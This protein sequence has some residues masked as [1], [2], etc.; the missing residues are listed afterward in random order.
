MSRAEALEQ[1]R[2]AQRN[3][4][5]Y[6]N[7]CISKGIYP[8]P[9][10]LNDICNEAQ[11]AGKVELGEIEI[12][13]DYIIG[14]V[15][16]GRKAAFAGNF[17]PLLSMSSE[18]S[19][20]W[21]TLCE[22]HLSSTGITDPIKCFEYMGRFYVQEGHKRVSVLKS[23]SA[24]TVRGTV[25]RLIPS[26]S[27]D[28]VVIAYYEFLRFY[29][30]ARIYHLSFSRP[31]CYARVQ[32]LLGF[33]E[34]HVWT[35]E[36]RME[37]VS[38]F[39]QFREACDEQLLKAAPDNSLSEV[40][41]ACL[42]VYPY[43]DLCKLSSAEVRKLVIALVPDMK[44]AAN[45]DASSVSTEPEELPEKGI[46][47]RLLDGITRP[48][49]NVAFI[50]ATAP[51]TSNWTMGH[52]TGRKQ[53]EEILGTQIRVKS[54]VAPIANA[55]EVMEAAVT[56][57][58]AQMVVATAP[59]LL[60][61]ARRLAMKHPNLK[62]LVC[63]LSV[64]YAGIRTYYSRIYEAKFVSG[65][66]AGTLA[67]GRPIGYVARY[68][69]LGV[70]ASIN[71]F[72]MG[73]S[74]TSPDSEILLE[75]SCVPGDP[76]VSLRDRGAC[77]VSAHP[78]GSTDLSGDV[79]DWSTAMLKPDGGFHPLASDVCNWGKLYEMIFKTYLSGMWDAIGDERDSSINYWWGMNSGV[80]DVHVAN[81]LPTGVKQLAQI[82]KSGLKENQI[83]L[84]STV[85]KDQT[86]VERIS[87][88][89]WLS[90]EEIMKMN[91][92][93]ESV[94]GHIPTIDELLPMSVETTRLL[95]LPVS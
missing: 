16:S 48:S 79:L 41:L 86:G 56:Q 33:E 76:L 4:M 23:Y 37:F 55:D 70:P 5:K 61:A 25:T 69:I 26:W 39:W 93:A 80:V 21:V 6:Y 67:K 8:Y 87:E 89:Q 12:P 91:W 64:P 62:I 19:T 7:Q 30:L 66:I 95:A 81:D 51:E 46:V 43:S 58:G 73:A 71:A 74:M 63:A 77:I 85:L 60:A 2:I 14:T 57:D 47:G 78:V 10:V 22:A 54:Y 9:R 28:P 1:Y 90:T 59:T 29:K 72:A 35:D 36:E 45:P 75:W 83:H 53:V 38:M 82:L 27:D 68:P 42:E 84:F 31:G 65:A 44:V 49:V 24:P 50:H 13:S 17:M 52:E 20:K 18:F 34:D 11:A 94:V 92:L 32:Q 40:I 88:E 3:G 15:A